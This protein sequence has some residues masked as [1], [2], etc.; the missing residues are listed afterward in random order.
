MLVRNVFVRV[1]DLPRLGAL[2][3]LLYMSLQAW[4][5]NAR[6]TVNTSRLY[7]SLQAWTQNVLERNSKYQQA[8]Y[9]ATSLDSDRFREKQ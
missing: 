6:E 3:K 1:Y 4:T 2:E 8:I 7:T 5:Q 9:V